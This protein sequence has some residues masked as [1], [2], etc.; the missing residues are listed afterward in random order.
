MQ[1]GKQTDVL[2]LDFSKAFDKPGDMQMMKLKLEYYGVCGKA[3]DW[4][5]GLLGAQTQAVVVEG[6][7]SYM[8]R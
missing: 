7:R 4:I 2:L 3:R 5:A 6:D 1:D 8:G